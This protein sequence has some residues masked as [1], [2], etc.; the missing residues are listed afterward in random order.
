MDYIDLR[1][2]VENKNIDEEKYNLWKEELDKQ[3]GYDIEELAENEPTLIPRS[4][5]KGYA[6]ELAEDIG[7]IS[8]DMQWPLNCIDWEQAADELE[9]DYSSV[10]IEGVEYLFRSY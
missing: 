2:I 3:T 9:M 4:E 7:A 10:E 5:W 1:D 6:Q 8:R